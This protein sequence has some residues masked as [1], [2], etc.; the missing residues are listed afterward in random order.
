MCSIPLRHLPPICPMTLIMPLELTVLSQFH[1]RRLKS[2]YKV[3]CFSSFFLLFHL[4]LLLKDQQ[5]C[6][7]KSHRVNILGFGATCLCGGGL[8]PPLQ[9]GGSQS[10]RREIGTAVFPYNSIYVNVVVCPCAMTFSS[11]LDF[12]IHLKL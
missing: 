1:S 4:S 2:S 6:S 7:I 10:V 9:G 11:P 3:R 5:P 12:S 8:T